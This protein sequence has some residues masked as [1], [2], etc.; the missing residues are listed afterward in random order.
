[1]KKPRRCLTDAHNLHLPSFDASQ[2]QD[3][4]EEIDER[5]ELQLRSVKDQAS[6]DIEEIQT[7]ADDARLV[8]IPQEP[9]HAEEAHGLSADVEAVEERL[10]DVTLTPEEQV[11]TT[12]LFTICC[13]RMVCILGS[14]RKA[15]HDQRVRRG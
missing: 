2:C 9:K 3:H 10:C 12:H 15:P 7:E 14:L 4:L 11:R 13:F 6:V 1:M 5:L 8:A